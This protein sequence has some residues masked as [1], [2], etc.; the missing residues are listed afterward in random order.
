MIRGR[1]KVSCILRYLVYGSGLLPDM[2]RFRHRH[3]EYKSSRSGQAHGAGLFRT[4]AG[5]RRWS[6]GKAA[7]LN[8]VSTTGMA[9]ALTLAILAGVLR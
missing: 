3:L 4:V 9:I 5:L 7:V 2:I 6:I 1:T 8:T